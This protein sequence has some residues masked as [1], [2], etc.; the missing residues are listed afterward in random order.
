MIKVRSILI[1]IIVIIP[2][3]LPQIPILYISQIWPKKRGA[4][5]CFTNY[6]DHN[7]SPQLNIHFSSCTLVSSHAVLSKTKPKP[8][9][10]QKNMITTIWHSAIAVYDLLEL[11]PRIWTW[12]SN[13][14][15]IQMYFIN[16]FEKL[17]Q[18][19][20]ESRETKMAKDCRTGY[21]RAATGRILR[22]YWEF[23]QVYNKL[24]KSACRGRKC[25]RSEKA[26]SE[27]R[28]YNA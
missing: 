3:I 22:I 12:V 16:V 15:F 5:F 2:K 26:A 14:P 21:P 17:R 20:C 28:C 10:K 18:W 19:D 7:I 24:M 8:K 9:Q 13:L 25:V 1:F 11:C 27:I 6:F 4:G 23:L